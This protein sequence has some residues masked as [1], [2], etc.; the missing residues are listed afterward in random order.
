MINS[1]LA[2]DKT[3]I[4]VYRLINCKANLKIYTAGIEELH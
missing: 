1:I 4:T 2:K 3:T